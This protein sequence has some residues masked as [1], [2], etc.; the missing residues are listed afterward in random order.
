MEVGSPLSVQLTYDGSSLQLEV[1][2]VD[3]YGRT[4][5]GQL[6]QCPLC[7]YFAHACPPLKIS[8]YLNLT[9]QATTIQLPSSTDVKSISERQTKPAIAK[10]TIHL[11]VL[12]TKA[13]AITGIQPA[14]S[15][16]QLHL[17]LYQRPRPHV[18]AA[19]YGH[20]TIPTVAGVHELNVATW[21]PSGTIRETI[22]GEL[23][24]AFEN[25]AWEVC[26]LCSLV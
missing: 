4:E 21:R 22:S 23:H 24:S 11:D 6:S 14:K 16:T 5:L 1:Y 8:Q 2:G 15:A 20:C 17:G 9:H 7:P 3:I 12:S 19:G 26:G 18:L 25:T 10:H 13:S